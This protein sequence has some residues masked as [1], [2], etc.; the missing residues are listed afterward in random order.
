MSH[1]CS[2]L[3]HTDA[4]M[5]RCIKNRTIPIWCNVAATCFMWRHVAATQGLHETITL[6]RGFMQRR[7]LV[8]ATASH[9]VTPL[10]RRNTPVI[11]SV[12]II[13]LY[14]RIRQVALVK[15]DSTLEQVHS[16]SMLD[17]IRITTN[18]QWFKFKT[19]TVVRSHTKRPAMQRCVAQGCLR[20]LGHLLRSPSIRLTV[21]L[22]LSTTSIRARRGGQGLAKHL[23]RYEATVVSLSD[24]LSLSDIRRIE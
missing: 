4:T 6:Q 7:R 20:R 17:S 1:A 8:A 12:Q 16:L 11:F 22:T 21:L 2:W 14:L 24:F 9:R 23:T 18:S 3:V 10:W 5:P 15:H 19:N 13:N